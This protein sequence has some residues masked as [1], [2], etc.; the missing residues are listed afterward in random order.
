MYSKGI[1]IKELVWQL[2][3]RLTQRLPGEEEQ[4]RMAPP[5]RRNHLKVREIDTNPREGGVLILLY[6]KK[7]KVYFP[8]MLRTEYPGVHSGQVS[9]PGGKME[10][11]DNDLKAT[12]LR[13][14]KEEFGIFPQK[15][16]ILGSLTK[17]YIPPSNFLVS[18]FVGYTGN[19]PEFS[20]DPEEVQKL[21]EISLD[22]IA[23]KTKIK[24]K[25]IRLANGKKVKTP[26]FELNGYTVWGAT[27]MILS[28]FF[29]IFE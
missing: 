14:T 13:E 17:L 27:A 18:P 20:P 28:E 10:K 21:I 8:L 2:A 29:S 9:L 6:P 19:S 4:F 7:N 12:A 23:G 3:T 5:G 22:N 16:T 24:R 25:K 11:K 26:Y 15:I 1:N